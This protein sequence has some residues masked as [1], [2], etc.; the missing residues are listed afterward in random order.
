M[1][2]K[3]DLI[4]DLVKTINEKQDQQSER[5]VKLELNSDRNTE[6]LEHH[7]KR[8]DLLEAKLEKDVANL[9]AAVD[10]RFEELEQ[11]KKSISFIG[12]IIVWAGGVAGG[13]I[14]VIKL[15]SVVKGG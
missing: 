1:T 9:K 4:Y 2:D 7:I 10:K 12:K 6:D 14:G 8:T 11:P 5:L 3:L 13:V 15:I